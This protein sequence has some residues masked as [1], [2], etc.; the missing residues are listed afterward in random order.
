MMA[1]STDVAP[2]S[3]DSCVVRDIAAPRW[4][5]IGPTPRGAVSAR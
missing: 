4:K 1:Y 2:L 3:S 5:G